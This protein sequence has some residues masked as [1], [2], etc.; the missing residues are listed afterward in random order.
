[1]SYNAITAAIQEQ[2]NPT[3][4]AHSMRFFKTAKGQYGEGDMFL[5]LTVPMQ[6]VIAKKFHDLP[7]PAILR[8]LHSRYH[9]YRLIALLILVLQFE[10]GDDKAKKQIVDIYLGE[11][12]WINNWDLVNL[13]AYKILGAWLL[14]HNR[15]VLT[16]LAKS[17][18]M[19]ERRLAIVS[20]YAFILTGELDDTFALSTR[21]LTDTHDLMHKAVG[22]MLREA[23]KKDVA[24]L[25][26]FL[27]KHAK[28]MPRTM[29][30]YSI[31]KFPEK[32]RKTYLL[33][34]H[35]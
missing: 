30:R 27:H 8:L 32:K 29:L 9:E 14:T 31:E 18:N 16:R 12:K 28:T 5:G 17:S 23:G 21:L 3:R 1:M 7:I 19:W 11:T 15:R 35:L 4:A 34:K 25:E 24:Q 6:R 2:S 10:R 26:A 33:M 22:W 20:T 13:S